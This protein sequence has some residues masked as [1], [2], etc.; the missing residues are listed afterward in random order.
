LTASAA[1][2]V[3]AKPNASIGVFSL[4]LIIFGIGTGLFKS[5]ISPLLAEQQVVT[6]MKIETTPKGER[7]IVDPAVT[8]SRIFIYFYMCIN[9]GSLVGQ[10]AM[11][12]A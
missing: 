10:I 2:T 1:P 6:R 4:G 3:I 8:T 9:I 5:N 12:Y 7:I 11:V